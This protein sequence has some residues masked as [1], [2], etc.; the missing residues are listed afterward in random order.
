MSEAR[1]V[2]HAALLKRALLAID[3]L[4]AKVAAAERARSEPIAVVGIGCRFPG[5]A[6]GPDALWR[7][8]ADG[9]DGVTEVPADRLGTSLFDPDPDAVGKTYSRWGAFL[10]DVDRFDA[11]LLGI[12]PREAASMDPQQRLLLEVAWQSLEHAGIAPTSLAGGDAAVYAGITTNDYV[13]RLAQSGRVALRGRVHRLGHHTQHGR[14][15][16]CL[17]CSACTA[18]ACRCD[19]ACSSSSSPCIGRCR[20]CAAASARWRSPAA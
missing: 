10:E 19:T 7:L 11:P 9:V 2:D 3:Q 14:R 4:E 6:N 16:P 13:I 18:R 17:T 5:G 8:L 15:A 12:S 1:P 20:A